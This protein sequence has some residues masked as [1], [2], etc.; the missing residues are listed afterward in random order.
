MKRSVLGI[1][2]RGPQRFQVGLT[3]EQPDCR[4]GLCV[5]AEPGQVGVA[6]I[7]EQP[8]GTQPSLQGWLQ[9]PDSVLIADLQHPQRLIDAEPAA[10]RK[11]IRFFV[12][13]DRDQAIRIASIWSEHDTAPDAV[14]C[15]GANPV[16]PAG[17]RRL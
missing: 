7:S 13:Q 4:Q 15:D 6:D 14:D 2:Q 17:L 5:D 12:R 8:P 10:G 1:R 3:G 16:I 9:L 11:C